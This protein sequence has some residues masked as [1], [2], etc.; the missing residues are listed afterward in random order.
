[1]GQAQE[2]TRAHRKGIRKAMKK[3]PSKRSQSDPGEGR[4]V[5]VSGQ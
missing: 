1:M 2:A 3:V 4:K 5:V